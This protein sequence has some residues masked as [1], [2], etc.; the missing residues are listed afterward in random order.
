[1]FGVL[2]DGLWE[3][4]DLKDCKAAELL[5]PIGPWG[6]DE[7]L[8]EERRLITAGRLMQQS[9]RVCECAL[10]LWNELTQQFRPSK[11]AMNLS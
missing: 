8:E 6:R 11:R 7:N 1:M 9:L 5:V 4:T 10:D 3:F 2:E